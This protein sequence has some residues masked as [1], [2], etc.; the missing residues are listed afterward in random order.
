MLESTRTLVEE[1]SAGL[2]ANVLDALLLALTR[3]VTAWTGRRSVCFDI[4]GHGREALF[5]DTDTSRTI[6]WL[7][8]VYPARFVIDSADDIGRQLA[9]CK[10]RVSC[11]PPERHRLRSAARVVSGRRGARG[12]A[13]R[14]AAPVAV[15]LPRSAGSRQ[16]ERDALFRLAD[17]DFGPS[18]SPSGVRAYAIDVNAAIAAGRIEIEWIYNGA[19]HRERTIRDVADDMVRALSD[20]AARCRSGEGRDATPSD[21]PLAGLDQSRLDDVAA[22]LDSEDDD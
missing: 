13:G 21:F 1:L 19:L 12:A 22:L 9:A 15:Q 18:R 3:A 20:V 5:E 11:D 2:N 17:P 6:G 7:T 8:T 4:E 14:P 16:L 10:E